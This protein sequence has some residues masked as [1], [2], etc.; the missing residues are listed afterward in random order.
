MGFKVTR[1]FRDAFEELEV[2]FEFAKGLLDFEKVFE[3]CFAA[4]DAA[5]EFK[6]FLR[7]TKNKGHDPK[8]GPLG[9]R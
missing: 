6:N 9:A 2:A 3:E 4:S 7:L 1:D 8:I 5:R